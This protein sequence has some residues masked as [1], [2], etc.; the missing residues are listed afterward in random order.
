MA[1][2]RAFSIENGAS[3]S[4]D[5]PDAAKRRRTADP[6]CWVCH[7][8]DTNVYCKTCLRSYH[9]QCVGPKSTKEI[10]CEVCIRED[11]AK[12]NDAK[13]HENLK[14]LNGLLEYIMKRLLDSD[15]FTVLSNN[16][17]QTK[18]PVESSIVNAFDL[19]YI[20]NRV[21]ISEYETPLQFLNDIRWIKHN[22]IASGNLAELA[23]AKRLEQ[24]CKKEVYDIE[25]CVDCFARSNSEDRSSWF[26][27]VCDPPHLLVW[28][29][30][31]GHRP[32]KPAKV[33][34]VSGKSLKSK[35]DVRF[36]GDHDMADVSLIDCYLFS[37]E[38][39]NGKT[40]DKNRLVLISSLAEAK[41]Y[42][43]NIE[44]KF[45]CKFV[46]Y[47]TKT[48]FNSS[49]IAEY[50]KD[51]VPN[52]QLAADYRLKVKPIY[53]NPPQRRRGPLRSK[54]KVAS[55]SP[56]PQVF[57]GTLM[58][59]RV[60][61]EN[62]DHLVERYKRK[63]GV[64]RYETIDGKGPDEVVTDRNSEDEDRK[65]PNGVDQ[66]MNDETSNQVSETEDAVIISDDDDP[67]MTTHQAQS[68]SLEQ[69]ENQECDQDALLSTLEPL[70]IS[71]Q[72]TEDDDKA[73]A[74]NHS[75]FDLMAHNDVIEEI[76]E[77]IVVSDAST[78]EDI[79]EN[80]LELVPDITDTDE[81]NEPAD[82]SIE[83][84]EDLTIRSQSLADEYV[85][86][87]DEQVA[88][89]IESKSN[90]QEE[91]F[92]SSFDNAIGAEELGENI[93]QIEET[94]AQNDVSNHSQSH[95][96][97]EES[98]EM[99]Q[100][101][102][103]TEQSDHEAEHTDHEMI[104]DKSIQTLPPS[105]MKIKPSAQSTPFKSIDEPTQVAPIDPVIQPALIDQ[106]TQPAP[107]DQLTQSAKLDQSIES[108]PVDEPFQSTQI[109]Q[110]IES[111]LIDEPIQST[112]I[113]QPV[114]LTPID[115][116]E[117]NENDM[118]ARQE[119]NE[120]AKKTESDA[121]LELRLEYKKVLVAY[122]DMEKQTNEAL[123]IA[124]SQSN[125]ITRL[126]AQVT[127]LTKDLSFKQNELAKMKVD[128]A[129]ELLKAIEETKKKMWCRSCGNE[130]VKPFHGLLHAMVCSAQCLQMTWAN[131]CQ[132]GEK[133]SMNSTVQSSGN[134]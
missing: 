37:K 18:L 118:H 9:S 123:Q 65:P 38:N 117:N 112:S 16:Y 121:M 125:I 79:P 12:S 81:V 58:E 55:S 90:N 36:F 130:L 111:T 68:E 92:M 107:I 80:V 34:G 74:S 13:W 31:I 48:P 84:N 25:M 44:K 122:Q 7:Q 114:Q 93:E 133:T 30:E 6:Y 94:V 85:P 8:K 128:Y 132:T 129:A 77:N 134:E 32:F 69:I 56:V 26:T 14:R 105:C 120:G 70:D 96:F 124:Q 62:C 64:D 103:E 108:T 52:V 87:S 127:G 115:P 33:I 47:K 88:T 71:E 39:P 104:L 86:V 63:D 10:Q 57:N 59:T 73:T 3:S 116:P 24:F 119:S 20:R 45:E 5:E 28:A 75:E 131:E 67:F 22:I 50:L 98:Q 41:K 2:K 53:L 72:S 109:N 54:S 91:V 42:I 126:E 1:P 61:L 17:F 11:L 15:E 102:N 99:T 66:S 95:S 21:Q 110:S 29:R 60:V 51:M 43:E 100:N 83:I 40:D 106:P 46:E 19:S 113:D 23:V 35:I 101:E 78:D 76:V 82:N 97:V 27:Q 49:R 4:R 89:L